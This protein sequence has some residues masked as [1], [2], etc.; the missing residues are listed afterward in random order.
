[1]LTEI[2]INIGNTHAQFAVFDGKSVRLTETIPTSQIAVPASIISTLSKNKDVRIFVASVVPKINEAILQSW[3]GREITF[4]KWEMLKKVDFSKVDVS[5]VGAD[6]LANISAA[7]ATLKLPAIIVDCG[8]AITTEVIDEENRF[9]GGA[10]IPGRR[11]WRKALN[12]HTGQLPEIELSESETKAVGTTTLEALSVMDC[13]VI[14]AV[15]RII[16]K[17]TEKVKGASVYF[18]GGDA[19]FFSKSLDGKLLPENFT[20]VGL[21]EVV[22]QIR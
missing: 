19:P 5:T 22:N 11:L 10:I 4:L 3:Q 6:R 17:T 8:T 15:E 2:L 14:G 1:M 12:S 21:A 7:V 9:L 18:T 13:A 16:A 20:L